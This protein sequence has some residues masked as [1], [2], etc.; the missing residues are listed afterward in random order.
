MWL[1]GVGGCHHHDRPGQHTGHADGAG[2]P[3]SCLVRS[4]GEVSWVTNEQEGAEETEGQGGQQKVAGSVVIGS[5]TGGVV[6]PD[7]GARA[8]RKSRAV[9]TASAVPKG[10]R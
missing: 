6:V 2:H 4:T 10:S 3:E 7:E 8:M 9:P 1:G 5:D